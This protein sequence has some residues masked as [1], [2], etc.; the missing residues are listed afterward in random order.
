MRM[1][2]KIQKTQLK[3]SIAA[4]PTRMKPVRS[5]R[6]KVMPNSSTFCWAI[7]GHPEAGHDQHED[8]QVV[9]RQALLGDVAGEVLTARRP[10]AEPQHHSPK[11]TAMPT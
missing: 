10:A 1:P 8:E 2:P 6:A 9:D 5:T 3:F 7:R 4:A 11:T